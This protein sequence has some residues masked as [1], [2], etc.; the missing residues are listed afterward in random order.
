MNPFP[1]VE[2]KG[3]NIVVSPAGASIADT[4]DATVEN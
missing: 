1:R 2:H 3:I 4:N